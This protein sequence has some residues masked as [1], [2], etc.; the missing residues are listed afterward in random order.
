MGAI[1]IFNPAISMSTDAEQR[2][3]RTA[4]VAA[5][6]T[7]QFAASIGNHQ[8]ETSTSD[9]VSV[10]LLAAQGRIASLGGLADGWDAQGSTRVDPSTAERALALLVEIADAALKDG[11]RIPAPFVSPS[12]SGSIGLEWQRPSGFLAVE[13]GPN[14]TISFLL[15]IG[16]SEVERT[17]DSGQSL[18]E[19]SREIFRG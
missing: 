15:D 9:S 2:S 19:S 10:D 11:V 8:V 12:P 13:C 6:T 14:G 18:W 17:A 1:D 16:G 4:A 7:S 5:R 3:S